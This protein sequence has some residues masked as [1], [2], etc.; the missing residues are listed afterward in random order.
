MPTPSTDQAVTPEITNRLQAGVP[1]ALALLAGMQLDVFTALA[2]DR[3]TV[4][5][6]A[7]RLSLPKDRLSRLLNALVLTGLLVRDDAHYANSAE[8]RE[9]LVKGKPAYMFGSTDLTHQLWSADLHTAQTIKLGKPGAMLDFSSMDQAALTSFLWSLVPYSLPTGRGFAAT[10]DFSA[11]KSVIDVGGGAGGVL[12]GLFETLP[13]LRGT[14]F[15]LPNV[16]NAVSAS[17][18]REAWFDRIVIESGNILE[19]PPSSLHD[20]AILRSVLQVLSP[21]EAGIAI[22][23][24]YKGLRPGGTIYI[25]GMGII[26]DSRLSPEANVYLDLTLM[27]LYPEGRAYT[28]GEHYAWLDTAGFVEKGQRK[29]SSGATVIFGRKSAKQT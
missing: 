18:H 3:L 2:N 4:A 14:I 6:I 21:V 16:A 17:A 22:A 20:A 24:T 28:I 7:G 15:E 23:N 25:T 27:N 26:D 13:Q 8:A 5:E 19:A 9:F 29:L 1:P 11:C 10:F 12:A